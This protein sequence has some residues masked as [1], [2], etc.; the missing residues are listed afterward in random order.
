[1]GFFQRGRA[2]LD[3]HASGDLAHRLEQGQSAGAGD[4]FIGNADCFGLDQIGG[5]LRIGGQVEIGEQYLAFAQ[6]R[7]FDGLRFLDLDHHFAF[8]ENF[9]GSRCDCRA[10]GNIFGIFRADAETSAG[11]DQHIMAIGGQFADRFGG[12]AD[13]IFVILDFSGGTNAHGGA[14]VLTSLIAHH[15]Q[16]MTLRARC[17]VIILPYFE[18][19]LIGTGTVQILP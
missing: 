9:G 15:Y 5:L 18:T 4:R 10:S 7:A 11:L 13:P 1:M 3:R 19:F 8:F 2:G 14:P 17:V 16:Q 6:H 12:Q